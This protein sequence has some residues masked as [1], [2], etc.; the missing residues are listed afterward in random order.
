MSFWYLQFSQKV[1]KEFDFTTMVHQGQLFSFDFWENWR[2]QKDISKLTDLWGSLLENEEI[3]LGGENHTSEIW[4]GKGPVFI[5]T[6]LELVSTNSKLTLNKT[7]SV[8]RPSIITRPSLPHLSKAFR[9]LWMCSLT[10][11]RRPRV[12]SLL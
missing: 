5:E 8:K 1:N 4:R 10:L 7:H 12:C 6:K 2:Q 3:H 11:W 9:R